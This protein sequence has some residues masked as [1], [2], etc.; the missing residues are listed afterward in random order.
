ML[1]FF[2]L[3]V[4]PVAVGLFLLM[5]IRFR[6]N[7]EKAQKGVDLMQKVRE[8]QIYQNGYFA[9]ARA[10]AQVMTLDTNSGKWSL[11]LTNL[12]HKLD[13]DEAADPQLR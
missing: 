11:E 6:A 7:Y 9:G 10:V 13:V 4:P 12:F 2:K 8:H 5:V 1:R 3:I